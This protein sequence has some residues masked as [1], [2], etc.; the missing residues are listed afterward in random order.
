MILAAGL[1]LGS[2]LGLYLFFGNGS[3]GR[4]LSQG[5][6]LEESSIDSSPIIGNPAPDFE[7]G[8]LEGK[9]TRLSDLHGK[10][11][12]LNF[13]ATW[14]LPCRSEMPVLEERLA[15]NSSKLE[16][17]AINFDEPPET[18]SGFVSELGLNLKVL[19]DPGGLVQDLYRV[20]GYPTTYLVDSD[21]IVRI[22]H[23]GLM[24]ERQ[25]DGYLARVGLGQ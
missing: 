4:G 20:R 23:I 16:V 6:P 7:L 8:D 10:I 14:C 3:L 24:T 2:G 5:E 25:L 22:Q 9:S 18:V 19:L 17:L 11:V 1:I 13:W 15:A 12:L 21:G